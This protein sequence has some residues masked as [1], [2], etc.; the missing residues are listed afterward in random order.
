VFDLM[1]ALYVRAR[2]PIRAIIDEMR[3]DLPAALREDMALFISASMEG[4]TVFAGHAKP[5]EPRMPSIER[6][7]VQSFLDLV[8]STPA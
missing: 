3:P 7:A 5:F 1:H 6:I 2:A 4:M 8:R